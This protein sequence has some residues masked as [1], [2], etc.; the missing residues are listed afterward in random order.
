MLRR[1]LTLLVALS[2]TA[3]A[4]GHERAVATAA[5]AARTPLFDGLGSLHHAVST[6]SPLAQ[7]YFDQGLRLTYAFNHAEA[8]T[9]FTE[10]ARLDPTC[11]MCSWGIALALG[12]NINIPMDT[13]QERQ[14]Y[15]AV[16]EAQ[17][18]SAHAT[19][20]ERRYI[21]ALAKRYSAVPGERRAALDSAYATA[22]RELARA[23]PD[24]VDAA[25]LYAESM[26]DLRPWNQWARD[27]K[28]QPGTEE[29]VT[30]L[31]R[32][33]ARDPN[34]PGA[35]H[36]YI[37]TV[38][39]SPTPQRALP[40]AERL[41]RLMPGAGHLVHMPAHVYMRVG[42][43][44]DAARAN[45][46]AAHAD[47]RYIE[48][49]HTES[50][51]QVGYYPH[52][53]HFLW[54]ASMMEGRSAVAMQAA[55][56]V[57]KNMPPEL[58]RQIPPFEVI[59]PSPVYTMLRFRRWDEVLREPAPPADLRFSSGI[60]HYARGVALAATGRAADAERERDTLAAI[61]AAVPAAQILG[62]VNS[63]AAVLRLA[64]HSLNGEIA[65]ARGDTG[66]AIRELE[67]AVEMED[68]LAYDEPPDW[69]APVRHRLGGLLLAAGRPADAERVYREDLRRNPENGWA[70]HG[71][72]ASL[73]AQQKAEAAAVERRWRQAW[74]RADVKIE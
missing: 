33:I 22:M 61:A 31:E 50:V 65:A 59:A 5:G 15:A 58:L 7:R 1:A 3:A 36:Y 49:P 39:A 56:D 71:L 63:A 9:A 64:T 60:W 4:Q 44:A 8:V 70:L 17:A 67:S 32:V 47:E 38:E 42:R 30:T 19:A 74:A 52:N 13:A 72:A 14:A 51:Y 28:P 16:R 69:Y 34:H 68:G 54:A 11:A 62:T 29:V 26:L 18:R 73:R 10:A 12:P 20:R 24:D 46:H 53:L 48:G 25:T 37:H 45:E 57:T 66:L 40:C 35:C 23:Y 21:A 55:R 43:Y 2:A 6:T 41:P 27:G